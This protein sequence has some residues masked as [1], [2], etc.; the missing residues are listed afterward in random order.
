MLLVYYQG[1]VGPAAFWLLAYLLT[2]SEAMKAV[3][4]EFA[5][6]TVAGTTTLNPQQRT[7]VFGE[8][9]IHL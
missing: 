7:P 6:A 8:C 1:N 2:H 3:K 9:Y 5:S 4:R